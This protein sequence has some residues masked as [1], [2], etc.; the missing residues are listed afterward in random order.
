MIH[1]CSGAVLKRCW[2]YPLL[3]GLALV[4]E[5][6]IGRQVM[7]AEKRAGSKYYMLNNL[8]QSAKL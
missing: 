2:V 3:P 8:R 7:Y 5:K 1:A 6:M 4:P